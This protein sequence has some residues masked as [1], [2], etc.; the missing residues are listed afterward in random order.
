MLAT[1][2]DVYKFKSLRELV[3]GRESL[4]GL[5]NLLDWFRPKEGDNTRLPKE[6]WE[7]LRRIL[8][9]R[10]VEVDETK[11][12]HL[13][14]P[15]PIAN[16]LY[17]IIKEAGMIQPASDN[18]IKRLQNNPSDVFSLLTHFVGQS[19]TGQGSYPGDLRGNGYEALTE[20]VSPESIIQ[21]I[22][23]TGQVAYEGNDYPYSEIGEAAHLSNGN[24]TMQ[25]AQF[26]WLHQRRVMKN[27]A[28]LVTSETGAEAERSVHQRTF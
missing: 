17:E 28:N 4:I 13:I 27:E 23:A 21:A 8:A 11:P 10:I 2:S 26:L 19:S 22:I 24:G 20:I 25:A 15:V 1:L 12:L 5:V 3:R 14:Q 6:E 9:E 16:R 18:L 7:L